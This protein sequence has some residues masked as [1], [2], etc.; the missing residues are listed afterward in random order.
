MHIYVLSIP[1]SP[2]MALSNKKIISTVHCLCECSVTATI[3]NNGNIGKLGKQPKTCTVLEVPVL[4][5]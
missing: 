3:G 5:Y 1:I 2:Y 4:S